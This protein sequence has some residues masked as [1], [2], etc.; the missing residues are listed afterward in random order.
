MLASCG[1]RPS[2]S[3]PTQAVGTTL[4]FTPVADA[5]V[6]QT[7]PTTN[8]GS[9]SSLRVDNSPMMR[10]YLRFIVSGLNGSRVVSATLK[11]YAN[12]SLS[13]GFT[14]NALADN[15]WAE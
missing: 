5:F 9:D 10:S 4:T 14:V 2:I 11:L 15:T 13:K 12:S 8:Y 1:G 3:V 7:S 6:F